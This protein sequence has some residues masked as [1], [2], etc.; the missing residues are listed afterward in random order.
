M[1][2][3]LKASFLLAALLSSHIA[4]AEEIS[5]YDSEGAAIAYIDTSNDMTIYLWEGDPVAY[6]ERGQYGDSTATTWAGSLME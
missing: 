5:L 6:Y 4:A 2:K 3:L 1:D